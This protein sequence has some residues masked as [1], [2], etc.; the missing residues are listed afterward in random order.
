MSLLLRD[1]DN[2]Y[3]S[4]CLTDGA[5]CCLLEP[6]EETVLVWIRYPDLFIVTQIKQL[7]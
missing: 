6:L 4:S 2:S 7:L 5:Q 3:R 1:G